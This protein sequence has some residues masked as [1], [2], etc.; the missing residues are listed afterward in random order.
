MKT[1]PEK[2]SAF[3]RCALWLWLA[4]MASVSGNALAAPVASVIDVS[5]E[6]TVARQDS[7]SKIGLFDNL[8]ADDRLQLP[9][10]TRLVLTHNAT[11]TEYS[12]AAP[13]E[14]EVAPDGIRL[15]SGSPPKTRLLSELAALALGDAAPG[16]VVTGAAQM[17]GTTQPPTTPANGET[18]LTTTP[19]FSWPAIASVTGYQ[20]ELKNAEGETLLEA[21]AGGTVWQLDAARPLNWGATYDWTLNNKPGER[22]F[23][24]FRTFRV[25]DRANREALARIE[26]K[27]GDAFAAWATYARTL[28]HLG[29]HSAARTV[30]SRLASERPDL[31]MLDT[32]ARG[33]EPAK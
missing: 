7:R 27:T 5:G 33:A 31:P 6:V 26:P 30:W 24:V 14:I 2:G 15:R 9:G 28:E 16:R 4:A 17:R 18:I 19:A 11:R 20:L 32:W 22:P 1:T 23:S 29:A 10:G 12:F 3:F 25:I 13:A 8:F 21:H